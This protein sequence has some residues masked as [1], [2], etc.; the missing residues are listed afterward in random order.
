MA[1]TQKKYPKAWDAGPG[2]DL[3][4]LPRLAL[5]V[6]STV[7]LLL[8]GPGIGPFGPFAPLLG[9]AGLALW[10]LA[11]GRT[12]PRRKL[13]EWFAGAIYGASLMSWVAYITPPSVAWIGIGW[14]LYYIL[15]GALLRRLRHHCGLPL[16][17]ALSYTAVES[18]RALLPTP[19]GLSWIRMGH[20]AAEFEPLLGA[21]A[22][23]GVGGIGFLLAALGG[24]VAQAIQARCGLVPS[25]AGGLPRMRDTLWVLGLLLFSVGFSMTSGFGLS[26]DPEE[27]FESGPRLLLVQPGIPQE[28]KTELN[29]GG[30]GLWDLV[31]LQTALTLNGV[32]RETAAG[33]PVDLV[34]WGESMLPGL[35][36]HPG[37]QRA[38]Q[39]GTGG[40]DGLEWPKWDLPDEGGTRF[41]EQWTAWEE[42]TLGGLRAGAFFGTVA[43]ESVALLAGLDVTAAR[44]QL[45]QAAFVAGAILYTEQAGRVGRTNAAI[46]WDKD[47]QHS[48]SGWKRHLVPGAETLGGLENWAWARDAA[49]LLMPYTP[50]FRGAEETGILNF[51][52]KSRT[53]KVG[54][55]ICFD[56]GYEDVFLDGAVEGEAD[57]N[58]VLSNEAWYRESQEFD[59]MIA[60]SSLWA[61]S[62]GR[63]IARAT[64]SGISAVIGPGGREIGRL[65][66]AG[67]DRAVTGSVA[68]SVP[69][70]QKSSGA[71]Q[72]IYSRTYRI[73]NAFWLL[74]PLLLLGVSNLL[75]GRP[76]RPS[77]P[78]LG[79][80]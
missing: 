72:T 68:F 58:L 24:L 22:L 67:I 3:A 45:G 23:F 69:V 17:A 63:A 61:V 43:P 26:L 54:V 6:L 4:P 71:P 20:F 2:P 70:P 64:N 57:F 59:Q 46:L 13:I 5:L 33:T 28:R 77:K 44:E 15:A 31:N 11:A 18:L 40:P 76:I 25:R 51:T 49:H 50:D 14:G 38:H 1:K 74:A 37:L 27:D 73:W 21:A 55:G 10:A 65:Q 78:I 47:G 35:Y 60:M 80:A 79:P 39:W 8:S 62:S 30:N 42:K 7:I 29:N 75:G 66:V 52:A 36:I 19:F 53:W 56:N 12:G 41:I 32:A 9:V 16:A 34:C 48:G